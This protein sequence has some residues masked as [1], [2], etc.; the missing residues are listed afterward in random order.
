MF[1]LNEGNDLEI[2][3][4][5]WIE[6]TCLEQWLQLHAYRSVGIMGSLEIGG[7]ETLE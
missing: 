3:S 7:R 5:C 6:S 4:S 2:Y 1:I